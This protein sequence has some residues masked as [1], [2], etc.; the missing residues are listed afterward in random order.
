MSASPL[1]GKK[2]KSRTPISQLD[3]WRVRHLLQDP[4]DPVEPPTKVKT[5]GLRMSAVLSKGV[6]REVALIAT[7]TTPGGRR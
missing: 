6:W 5:M 3:M 7:T 1:N 4:D 2:P